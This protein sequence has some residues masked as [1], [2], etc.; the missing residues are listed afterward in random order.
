MGW[1]HDDCGSQ[2]RIG[3]SI[4]IA[5]DHIALMIFH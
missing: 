1:I 2:I 3:M 4:R 5:H